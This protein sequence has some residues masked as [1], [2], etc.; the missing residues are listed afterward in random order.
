MPQYSLE[1]DTSG[2][3]RTQRSGIVYE[4][5]ALT[6]RESWGAGNGSL[7]APC[8]VN[9]ISSPSW[10]RDMVGQ[11]YVIA[12]SSSLVLSRFIPERARAVAGSD[13]RLLFCSGVDQTG[14]G[15]TPQ[16][17]ILGVGGLNNFANGLTKWPVTRWRQYR[18][19]FEAFPY[20]VLSDADCASIA[21]GAGAYPGAVELYRYIIRTRRSYSKEQALP[22]GSTGFR[23]TT[24][25]KLI[26]QVG[27][28]AIEYADVTYKWIRVPVGWPPP[29]GW[30]GYSMGNPWPPPVGLSAA[31]TTFKRTRDSYLN[32]VNS[33]WFDVAS[34][35]GYAFPPGTL[36]YTGYSDDNRYYDAAGDWVC[37][38]TF[39]FKFRGS[40]DS[41]KS[42]A[43]NF[44]GWNYAL[45]SQGAWV[46]INIEGSG[47]SGT[48]PYQSRD[49]N[50]LFRYS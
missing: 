19:I 21:A 26:G 30:T 38:V 31:N 37:D 47:T 5:E 41:G 42:G 9:T 32:T 36:L 1:G 12:P 33:T 2:L 11:V 24:S 45:N 17:G 4:I 40:L 16:S 34:P 44:G 7:V 23:D 25:G 49:F 13:R 15:Q 43:G 18:A 14:A 48:P 46:Y 39:N 35:D 10:V 27:F 22:A 28:R 50:N 8:R 6:P 29:A 3:P 20:K